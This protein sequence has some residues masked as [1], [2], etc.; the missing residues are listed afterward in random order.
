MNAIVAERL[1]KK[2]GDLVAVDEISFAVRKGE[3]FGF[4]GPKGASIHLGD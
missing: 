2:Y 4:L 1:V 3:C